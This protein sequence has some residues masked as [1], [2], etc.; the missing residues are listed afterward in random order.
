MLG[1]VPARPQSIQEA[2][3]APHANSSDAAATAAEDEATAAADAPPLVRVAAE[4]VDYEH[5]LTQ[6]KVEEGDELEEILTP[7][8]EFVYSASGEAALRGVAKGQI[9]QVERRGYYICDT[10]FMRAA[11]PVRL[12]FIPDGKNMVGVKRA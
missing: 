11:D 6:D 1:P 7:K 2:P 12:L 4:L 9:I 5:L 3:E 8:T 10:P